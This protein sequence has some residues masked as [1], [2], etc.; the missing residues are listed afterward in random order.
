MINWKRDIVEEA[1][2]VMNANKS[3]DNKNLISALS[4]EI[5]ALRAEIESLEARLTNVRMSAWVGE[6][7]P[8]KK[9]TVTFDMDG[10]IDGVTG[11]R[12][13]DSL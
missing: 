2:L 4:N 9:L 6:Q 7:G 11:E 5:V 1:Q 10:I 13:G 8:I 12:Y 3:L